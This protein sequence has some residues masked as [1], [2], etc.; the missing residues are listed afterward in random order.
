MNDC[1][2]A[3]IV[4]VVV[5]GVVVGQLKGEVLHGKRM[6]ALPVVLVA[7]GLDALARAHN[8]HGIDISCISLSALFAASI[9]LGQ[10]A[11]M[12]LDARHGALR[13]KLPVRGLWLWAALVGSRVLVAVVAPTLG[14]H[15]A[16]SFGAIL[17][18]LGVNRLAQTAAIAARAMNTGMPISL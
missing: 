5:I 12:Q 1:V 7:I 4:G 3:G 14:A 6:V 17:L 13:G 18:V 16:S 9:G 10:G 11:M 8:V 2:L 15:A